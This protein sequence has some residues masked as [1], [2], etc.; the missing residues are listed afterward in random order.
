MKP[1]TI[2]SQLIVMGEPIALIEDYFDVTTNPSID[3]YWQYKK[4]Q[5]SSNAAQI[6][7]DAKCREKRFSC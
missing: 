1:Q 4:Q 2:R 5:E 6:R 3:D 7:W